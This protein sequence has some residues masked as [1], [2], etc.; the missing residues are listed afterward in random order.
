MVTPGA[1]MTPL[2]TSPS[3]TRSRGLSTAPK[4]MGGVFA[5]TR[6]STTIRA[7]GGC[8]LASCARAGKAARPSA[9]NAVLLKERRPPRPPASPRVPLSVAT[10]KLK[11]LPVPAE[12]T[13]FYSAITDFSNQ[14]DTYGGLR[15]ASGPPID[16]PQQLKTRVYRRVEEL[17]LTLTQ[18]LVLAGVS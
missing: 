17:G 8:A 10:I 2:P 14:S 3:N 13:D 6:A 7:S 4:M 11:R 5:A 9:A 18:V 12:K 15:L 1:R 16:D